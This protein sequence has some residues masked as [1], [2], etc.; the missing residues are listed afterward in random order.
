MS[1]DNYYKVGGSLEYQHP[2]YVRRKADSDLYEGLKNGEFCYVLNSRQMGKSSLRVQ[3]MKQLKEQGFKCASIDMTRIGSHVTPAEWYAGVV[4]ELLRGFGLT[5]KVN[6]SSW[7]RD[8]ELLPPLQRLRELIEDVLLAEFSQKLVIFIDEIDSII[9]IKFK[10]DF[11]A[12]IRACYNQ[13]VDN[14]EYN[15]L[16]FCLLGVATPSD[17][18]EDKNIST[19]FNIGRAIE[20]TGFQLHEVQPLVQGLEGRVRKPEVVLREVLQWTGGQPFLTQKLCKLIVQ[21]SGVRSQESGEFLENST[22]SVPEGREAECVE[23]LVRSAV[24]QLT[25]TQIVENWET[26]DEPEHLRTI[27]DRILW[28]QRKVQLLQ[29]YQQILQSSFAPPYQGG[30]GGV[31]ANDTPEHMELRL[32]GLVVKQQGKLRVYNRIYESVFNQS[33]V[34]NALAEAGLLPKV[35]ETPTPQAEIQALEQAVSKALRQLESQPIEALLLAIQAGQALKALMVDGRPLQDYPTISPLSALQTIL[36]NIRERNQFNSYLSK[37]YIHDVRFSPDGEKFVTAEDDGTIQL[38]KQ[39]GQHLLRWKAHWGA[40]RSVSFSPNGDYLATAGRDGKARLWNLSGQQITE[41]DNH[42]GWGLGVCFSPDGQQLV[43]VGGGHKARLWNLFGQQIAQF[44]GHRSSIWSVSFSSDGQQLATAGMDGKIRLWNLSGQQIAQFEPHQGEAWS[45]NFSPDGQQLATAGNDNIARLWNLSGQLLVQLNGH[46]GMVR[47]VSF[48]PDGQQLATAGYD[49]TVRIWNLLGQQ[50]AQ[51]N[52][53]CAP[54]LSVCYSP[55]GQYLTTAGSDGTARL[56]DLSEKYLP[57]LKGHQGSV[58]SVSF[59]PDGQLIATTGRDGTARLW[60]LSGQQLAQFEGHQGSVWTVSFSPNGQYI[61]TTGSDS[62]ARLWNLSGQQLAQFDGH[63]GWVTRVIFSPDEQCLATVGRDG[64]ARLWDLSGQLISQVTPQQGWVWSVSFSSDGQLVATVGLDSTPP[65]LDSSGRLIIQLKGDRGKIGST[66]F[67]P[68]GQYLATASLEDGTARLWNLSGQQLAQFDG[69][70]GWVISVSFSP[71]G[72]LVATGGEDGSVCLW[73]L[74]GRKIVRFESNQGTIYGMSFSPTGECLATAGKDGTVRLWRVEGL[75][76]LLARGC[77]WL[78]DYFVTHP[79]ALEK[80]KVC[81]NRFKSVEAGK[82]LD[83]AGDVEEARSDRTATL[84]EQ[85]TSLSQQAEVQAIAQLSTA[86]ELPCALDSDPKTEVRK[87]AAKTLVGLFG[88]ILSRQGDIEK[89]VAAYAE[90][91]TLDPT[92]E[93]PAAVGNNLCWWGS[94][95]GN[96]AEVMDACETAVALEPENGKFRDSRGL[97]RALTGNMAGAIEDFQAFVDW[98]KDEEK[99]LKRQR[100]IDALRAGE[101]PFT[102]EEI[103]SLFNEYNVAGSKALEEFEVHQDQL[104]SVEANTNLA[105]VGEV[106]DV[107]IANFQ[108]SAQTSQPTSKRILW[109]DDKPAN[110]ADEIARLQEKGIE[111]IQS[112]STA[113]AMQILLSSGLTFDAIITDMGRTE[114]GEYQP[115][116]GISFI[117]AIREAGINLPILVYTTLNLYARTINEVVAAGGNTATRSAEELFAWLE[118]D[119][120]TTDPQEPREGFLGEFLVDDKLVSIYQGDITNLVTDVIVSYDDSY[121]TMGGSV[122]YSIREVGGDEIY[123]EASNLIPLSLGEV[124]VTTAGQLQAK[125]VFHAVVINFSERKGPS[126]DVI[127]QVVHACM[128]KASRYN[129]RSIAFPLLGTGTGG[130]PAKLAWEII[131]RQI[132]RDLSDGQQNV[133]EVILVIYGRQ[134]A[135]EL[136]IKGILEKIEKIGWRVLL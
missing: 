134:I 100:W 78:K 80:L 47:S 129:F 11:F 95:W 17:L 58:W 110:I 14:P 131:L 12:F 30:D 66:S 113:H 68:D 96:A 56:W 42:Q 72:Q 83:K 115:E 2:T 43:T 71:D 54:V 84:K 60:N 85:T 86:P 61:V 1:D 59:S 3:M 33:W 27:R 63:Q 51:L 49:G 39:S 103:E 117:K 94:L 6:F 92:L 18:I 28:S 132:I 41:F 135:K 22:F 87:L 116:A 19:P 90:A 53:H 88:E 108:S 119:R 102:E 121:L 4:S 75:D 44:D 105:E 9:K 15:R 77:D 99:R 26:Q 37:V 118:A 89:A 128:K 82:N 124:A 64:T 13:R 46:Q 29:L 136:N 25:L 40:V 107:A 10:E 93:I 133:V 106:E 109:V 81:Q 127:Q 5:R 126:E 70:Q 34:E 114:D 98:T 74:S 112:H 45:V 35:A 31:K 79:E 91:Q 62:T 111:V 52:G 38:W 104:S 76:D 8:R 69:N 120:Q 23:E 65:L 48:S 7:W 67:S 55:D 50:L 130:F 101:N 123:R 36:D 122:S 32:S 16:T 21:E 57:Q 97:A 73:D 125:K 24:A 20:L